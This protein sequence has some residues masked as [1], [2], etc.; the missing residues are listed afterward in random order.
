MLLGSC[1]S[2]WKCRVCK[3]IFGGVAEGGI[4]KYCKYCPHRYICT[5]TDEDVYCDDNT[6]CWNRCCWYKDIKNHENE[7]DKE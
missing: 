1:H 6:I 5:L 4:P 3:T 7:L 2:I